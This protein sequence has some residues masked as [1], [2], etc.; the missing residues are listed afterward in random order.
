MLI[1]WRVFV[2]H[3]SC[4]GIGV[5]KMQMKRGV[6]VLKDATFGKNNDVFIVVIFTCFRCLYYAWDVG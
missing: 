6:D 3:I 5:K 1:Y 2:S 4:V